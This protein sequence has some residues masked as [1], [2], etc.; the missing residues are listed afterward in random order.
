ML[1]PF[2]QSTNGILQQHYDPEVAYA[3][4]AIANRPHRHEPWRKVVLVPIWTLQLS[5][6]LAVLVLGMFKVVDV[7]VSA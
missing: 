4:H 7:P 3:A 6:A 1:F 2:R 5:M